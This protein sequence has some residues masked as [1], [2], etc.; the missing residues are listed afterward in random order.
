[1]SEANKDS[2]SDSDI[3]FDAVNEIYFGSNRQ[4]Y[5]HIWLRYDYEFVEAELIYAV[6]QLFMDKRF[7]RGHLK[8]A[9]RQFDSTIFNDSIRRQ[10]DSVMRFHFL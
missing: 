8:M 3:L 1:M 5:H 6:L 2:D 10:N 7:I 9:E 4:K